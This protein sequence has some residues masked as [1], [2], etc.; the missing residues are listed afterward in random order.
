MELNNYK[1]T[2]LNTMN[3]YGLLFN[4]NFPHSHKFT[5]KQGKV[6]KCRICKQTPNEIRKDWK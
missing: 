2:E 4:Q 3:W 6:L 5:G 1:Y